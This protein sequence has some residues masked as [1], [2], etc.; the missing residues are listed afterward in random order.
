MTDIDEHWFAAFTLA[1][2]AF[3]ERSIPVGAVLVDGAGTIVARGR[4]RMSATAA[5]AGQ[6]AGSRIEPARGGPRTPATTGP[7]APHA[8]GQGV[9]RCG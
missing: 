2:E 7:R 1:W 3:Q 8:I 5:P 6:L 4:N 9:A